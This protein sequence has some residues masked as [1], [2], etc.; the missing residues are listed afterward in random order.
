[1]AEAEPIYGF[2]GGYRFLSN[3]YVEFDGLTAEHRFQ[4]SK[5]VKDDDKLRILTAPNP[6]RAKEIGRSVQMRPDWDTYRHVAMKMV[7]LFKFSDAELRAALLDTGDAE[8]VEANTW[9]D[10]YW[11]V[12]KWTGSGDNHLGKLLME[13]RQEYRN[14]VY[15]P[16]EEA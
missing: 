1:M 8:L 12:D 4:A 15:S 9:H 7:L 14:G 2:E 10:T 11:G 13:L 16:Q 5:A 6:G 3:F